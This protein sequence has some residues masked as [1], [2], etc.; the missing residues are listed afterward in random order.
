MFAA[1]SIEDYPPPL[2]KLLASDL[3]ASKSHVRKRAQNCVGPPQFNSCP[4]RATFDK[5]NTYGR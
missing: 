1:I 4:T 5:V 3:S 2:D